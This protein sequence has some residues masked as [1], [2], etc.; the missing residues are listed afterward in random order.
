MS[1]RQPDIPVAVADHALCSDPSFNQ[2][3]VYWS[4]PGNVPGSPSATYWGSRSNYTLHR[5]QTGGA[6]WEFVTH[7]Y[8]DGAG[9]SD[10]IVLPD[11]DDPNAR[12]LAMAFQKTFHPPNHGIEGG[13]YDIG[14]ALLPLKSDDGSAHAEFTRQL[15]ANKVIPTPSHLL[16]RISPISS[17]ASK[18]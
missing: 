8:A 3:T 7:V 1:D 15:F 16:D 10:A 9:Y 2:G 11:P 6:S 18:Q 12:V 4:H 13:G 5:S 14:I 17:R